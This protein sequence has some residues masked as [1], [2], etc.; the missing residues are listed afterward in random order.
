MD[1]VVS[2]VGSGISLH[3][4]Q[5]SLLERAS[6]KYHSCKATYVALLSMAQ[7]IQSSP[8]FPTFGQWQEMIN[9]GVPSI[10]SIGCCFLADFWDKEHTYNHH[11]Q[12]TSIDANDGWLSCDHTFKSA[13][14]YFLI[15]YLQFA[16]LC[17]ILCSS[18]T[19]CTMSC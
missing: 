15:L 6:M 2:M 8:Q 1:L 13:G 19:I 17:H 10:H 9:Y 5:E 11:M 3:G 7:G 14:L 12:T 16:L 18:A 4:I